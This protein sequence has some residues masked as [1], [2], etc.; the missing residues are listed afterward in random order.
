MNS[1]RALKKDGS[2]RLGIG[3]TAMMAITGF[4]AR[5]FRLLS[6]D[7][8]GRLPT[9]ALKAVITG[10]SKATGDRMLATTAA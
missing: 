7:S 8:F 3:L 4:P 2:G 10:S 9:G 5:G 6:L 1:R